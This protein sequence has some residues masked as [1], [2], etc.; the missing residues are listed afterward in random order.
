MWMGYNHVDALI[1]FRPLVPLLSLM[2]PQPFEFA[3]EAEIPGPTL[4]ITQSLSH[5]SHEITRGLSLQ[6]VINSGR[7]LTKCD[8]LLSLC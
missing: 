5:V 4:E 6:T 7:T 2:V 8:S 1:Q 3:F